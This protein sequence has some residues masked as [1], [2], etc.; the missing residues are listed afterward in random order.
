MPAPPFIGLALVLVAAATAW[1]AAAPAWAGPAGD[2]LERF[3]EIAAT[4]LSV[5]ED[6]GGALDPAS[7]A[8]MDALL[9]G[10]VLDSLQVGGPF[11][12]VEFIRER[13]DAFAETWGG[14]SLRIDPLGGGVLAG[15]F[16]LS[17]KGVSNSVRL[18]GSAKGKPALLRAWQ[19]D[20]VP[21]V[22]PWA[23][24][25]GGGAEILVSWSGT[26][27]GWGSWPLRL[28]LWRVRDGVVFAVWRSAERY[29]E[30]L[31]VSQVDVKPGR[32]NLR[33]EVRY[34]GWKPGCD[35][36]A[37]QEDRYRA[38]PGGGLTLVSR[39]LFNGWHRELG[40]SAT[41]FFSALASGDRKALAE[42]APDVALRARLPVGL[43]AEAACD[44]QNPDTPG[45]A[46]VAAAAPLPDGRRAPW[47]LWWSRGASGWRLTGA[48]PVLE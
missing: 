47:S 21:E 45:T 26:A 5:V 18:Y 35:V 6:T 7:Q 12:S 23:A 40:R 10:E 37:E 20:G 19:E 11:A 24:P 39:Q 14:A 46:V 13:L 44:S 33:H 1:A 15:R 30:G 29:P 41:R 3:R 48:A 36:Q 27:T 22:Y 38:D 4:R 31:W 32:V 16:R 43:L 25:A 8:E 42:L 28:E 2:R 17:A 9:D 34:P